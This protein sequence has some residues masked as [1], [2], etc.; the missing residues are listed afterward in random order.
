MG[1][2]AIGGHVGLSHHEA[3]T[4]KI[5]GDRRKAATKASIPEMERADSRLL[6]ELFGKVPWE[7]AFKS[8]GVLQCWSLF[9]NLSEHR[10]RQLQS[11]EVKQAGQKAGLAEQGS[12]SRA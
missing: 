1:E 12:S 5:L 2:E 9:R 8:S 6:R 4:L 7:T 10:N 11:V 3:V